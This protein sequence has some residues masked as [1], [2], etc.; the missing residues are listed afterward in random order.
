MYN[1]RLEKENIQKNIPKETTNNHPIKHH[2][3]KT[4]MT[5]CKSINKSQKT[6]PTRTQI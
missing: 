2:P 4:P 1:S 6:P 3:Y 5:S